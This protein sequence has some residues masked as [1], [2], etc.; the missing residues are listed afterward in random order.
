MIKKI[1]VLCALILF[2]GC[3]HVAEW[4]RCQAIRQ[5]GLTREQYDTMCGGPKY[6]WIPL[7]DVDT[8]HVNFVPGGDWARPYHWSAP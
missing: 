3:A 2:C 1:A 5:N 6:D 7:S 8:P 4:Q